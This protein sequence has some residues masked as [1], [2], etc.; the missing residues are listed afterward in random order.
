MLIALVAILAFLLAIFVILKVFALLIGLVWFLLIA[1][2]CGAIAESVM[3]YRS[4][5]IG[6]TAGVGLLGAL[7]GLVFAKILGLPMWPHFAGIP[8]LWTIVGSIGLVGTMRVVAPN[9]KALQGR[10][11]VSRW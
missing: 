8:I 2:L 4:G 3:H 7:V 11:D 6:T 10:R 9:R 1:T 5:G